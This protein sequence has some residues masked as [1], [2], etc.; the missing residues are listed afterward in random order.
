LADGHAAA[1]PPSP[2]VGRFLPRAP[3]AL[4]VLDLAAGSGRHT[5]LALA[6][7][8]EVVAADVDTDR[9][10]DLAGDPRATIETVDLEDG[11][12]WPFGTGRFGAVVVANYLYRPMLPA[13][14]DAV[15]AGGLL[16]YETFAR[17][18]ERFGRP[19]NPDF[20][21]AEG[22]LLD[23][24]AGRLSVVAYEHGLIEGPSPRVVQR[25]CAR[26]P[27]GEENWTAL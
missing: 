23:A 16:V 15:A 14:V 9:L 10:A 27:G 25:L 3:R 11:G 2:W 18:N 5:R 21:L 22:E 8:F 17:G 13:I 24:V 19:R 4:P 12:P 1:R 7:G 26:R 20:L 6:L